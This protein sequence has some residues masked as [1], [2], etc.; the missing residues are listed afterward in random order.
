M[1]FLFT[2]LSLVQASPYNPTWSELKSEDGWVVQDTVQT[3]VGKVV[4]SKKMVDNFP[5]FRGVTEYPQV[6]DVPLMIEIASDAE[7]AMEWSSAGVSE[8]ETLG[9]TSDYVDYYQYLDLFYPMAD[10]FW[11][12]RGHFE[13]EG[14]V[15][16]FRWE[17]LKD[18]GPYNAKYKQVVTAHPS[19][20]QTEINLGSW[21]LYVHDGQTHVE[22]RLCSHPS[23]NIPLSLQ[24]IATSQTLPTNV[25]EIIVETKRRMT[26]P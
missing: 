5:C 3:S 20:L 18:G 11:F 2:L 4:V 25:A 12:L 26:A 21:I 19:A 16:Y 9:R 13:R 15:H 6:L 14:N 17:A 8:A 22:D 7:S 23:G 10:R 1:M 24:S